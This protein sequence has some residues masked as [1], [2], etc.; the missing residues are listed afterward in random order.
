MLVPVL[1]IVAVLLIL[2][3]VGLYILFTAQRLD[4][5]HNRVDAAAAGLDA[6]LRRRAAAA[7]T[8]AV[9]V[10]LPP[11]LAV[12]LASAAA[13]CAAATGLGHDRE[14]AENVLS[15]R[16]DDIARAVPEVFADPLPVAREMYDEGVRALMART[17]YNDTVRDALM[18]RDRRLVRLLRLAGSAPHPSYFDMA[19][20]VLSTNRIPVV[21]AP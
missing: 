15:H 13:D 12:A 16:L 17:F 18:V 3:V 10:P 8:F 1:R 14:L 7:A 4:R 6:L 5:L 19:G 9:Q 11:D 20:S 21:S 2:S